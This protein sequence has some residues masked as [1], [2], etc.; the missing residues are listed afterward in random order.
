MESLLKKEGFPPPEK[1]WRFHD[2]RKWRF[3]FAWP[4]LLLALEV[5]GG[6][7][8]RG[9]HQTAKGYSAD[10]EKYSEAAILGWKVIRVTQPMI[11]TGLAI[12]LIKRAFHEV[13]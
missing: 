10:C 3:D 9:R 12:D 2:T 1:E 11:K 13:D 5:E 7:W 6:I 4:D 8:R